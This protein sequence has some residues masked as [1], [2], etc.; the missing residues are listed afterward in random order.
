MI[1][2]TFH[3]SCFPI[4]ALSF[5]PSF[6]FSPLPAPS[7]YTFPFIP[8]VHVSSHSYLDSFLPCTYLSLVYL[9]M[10]SIARTV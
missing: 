5:H 1:P 6:L 10:I 3:Q 2:C 7:V 9:M 4:D 8:A